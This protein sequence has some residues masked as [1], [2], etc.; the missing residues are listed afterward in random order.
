MPN[1]NEH[2]AQISALTLNYDKIISTDRNVSQYNI[3]NVLKAVNSIAAIILK[4]NEIA[5]E[6]LNRA[7]EAKKDADSQAMSSV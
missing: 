3:D 5:L 7:P 4:E 2:I 1:N 6:E